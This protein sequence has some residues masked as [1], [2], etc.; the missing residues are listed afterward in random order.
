MSIEGVCA[1]LGLDGAKVR[2]EFELAHVGWECDSNGWV[3]ERAG[4]RYLILTDHGSPYVAEARALRD[5]LKTYA[6]LISVTVDALQKLEEVPRSAK[7][8]GKGEKP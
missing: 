1:K 5:Q 6:D 7:K 2:L 3:V 8:P 4:K